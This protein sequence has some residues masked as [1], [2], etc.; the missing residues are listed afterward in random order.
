[1]EGSDVYHHIAQM[2]LLPVVHES[3]GRRTIG[4]LIKFLLAMTKQIRSLG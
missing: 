1:V 4:D 2:K 3:H